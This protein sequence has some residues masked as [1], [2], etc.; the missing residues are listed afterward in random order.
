MLFHL[1]FRVLNCLTLE[2]GQKLVYGMDSGIYVSEQ[3]PHSNAKTT[4][5][6][7]L[8]LKNITQIDILEEYGLLLVLHDKTLSSYPIELLTE[9][10]IVTNSQMNRK[11]K[12][13]SDHV[14]FFKTGFCLGHVFLCIVKSNLW[15]STIK[16]LEPVAADRKEMGFSKL[17]QDLKVF[18]VFSHSYRIEQSRNF[19]CP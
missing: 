14:N 13:V 8:S 4:T 2:D 6:R 10:N 17:S 11:A 19:I 16:V 7:V 1:V 9:Y 5:T 15:S 3:K 18:K 12:K